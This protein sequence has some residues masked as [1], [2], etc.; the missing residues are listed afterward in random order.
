MTMRGVGKP[1]AVTVTSF[2]TG[3]FKEDKEL[4]QE[5]FSKCAGSR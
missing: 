4:K 3:A 5:F 1:G 2:F